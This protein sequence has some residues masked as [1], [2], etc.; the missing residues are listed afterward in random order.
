MLFK[1]RLVLGHLR[2]SELLE[3]FKD[4]KVDLM[5]KTKVGEVA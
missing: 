2:C 1:I 3:L 4:R 5:M